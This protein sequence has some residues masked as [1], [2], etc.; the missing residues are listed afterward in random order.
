MEGPADPTSTGAL[1]T[2]T[3]AWNRSEDVRVGTPSDSVH[4]AQLRNFV[5]CSVCLIATGS[6]A[7]G[8]R[9]Q[10]SSPTP[11]G[12]TVPCASTVREGDAAGPPGGEFALGVIQLFIPARRKR[13]LI[14][15]RWPP[16]PPPRGPSAFISDLQS[17][18]PNAGPQPDAHRH[19]DKIHTRSPPPFLRPPRAPAAAPKQFIDAAL[20]GHGFWNSNCHSIRLRA[21]SPLRLRLTLRH[22]HT[23]AA[24]TKHSAAL[25]NPI[26]INILCNNSNKKHTLKS[27][28]GGLAFRPLEQNLPRGPEI[29]PTGG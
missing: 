5:R 25:I 4:Q 16:P 18:D 12:A 23:G 1:T 7:T 8:R 10:R 29:G 14:G 17:P 26:I 15:S 6:R 2:R 13:S 22:M 3:G 11:S 21:L 27:E 19:A 24:H 20:H 9:M 28:N